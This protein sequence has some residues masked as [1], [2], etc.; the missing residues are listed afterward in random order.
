MFAH[1][2]SVYSLVFVFQLYS[3]TC[4]YYL[5]NRNENISELKSKRLR[6]QI[7]RISE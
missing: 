1:D 6:S 7:T 4:I 5:C 3:R 2:F